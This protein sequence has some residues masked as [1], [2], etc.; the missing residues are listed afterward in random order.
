MGIKDLQL[1]VKLLLICIFTM[2]IMAISLFLQTH[3]EL[4]HLKQQQLEQIKANSLNQKKHELQSIVITA[5]SSLSPIQAQDNNKQQAMISKINQ[6]K[7]SDEGYFFINSLDGYGIANGKNQKVTNKYLLKNADGSINTNINN[8]IEQAKAGG[9]FLQ[10]SGRKPGFGEAKFPKLTYVKPIPN[11]QWFI[12]ASF[13]IDDIDAI[14]AQQHNLVDNTVTEIIVSN[15]WLTGLLTILL[16]CL[17]TWAVHQALSPLDKMHTKL[18]DIARGNGDLTKQL[19]VINRD[20]IGKCSTAFNDFSNKIKQLVIDVNIQAAQIKSA[21]QDLDENALTNQN[22]IANQK[23]KSE[24]LATAI[25]ELLASAEEIAAS[26]Q[27]AAKETVNA[28][29]SGN[30]TLQSIDLAI[31]KLVEL[32][33]KITATA[34]AAQ[35]FKHETDAIEKVLEVI[36][37]VAEQTNL[38][39]L[40]AAI[41]AARAGEYGKGFSVV[42]DEVRTLASKTRASTEEINLL[43]SKLQNSSNQAYL[44]MQASEQTSKQTM[45]EANKAKQAVQNMSHSI[46]SIND[47]NA[48]VAIGAKQQTTVTQQLNSNVHALFE[49]ADESSSAFI[50]ITSTSNALKS[51]ANKLAENMSQ[52]KV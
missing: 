7:F 29:L 18:Q 39:A 43:I 46:E 42:A 30:E 48:Q 35:D 21:S 3:S 23:Q 51:N 8:Q 13:F 10:Y 34:Q 52:F 12:G 40:N 41:E 5:L 25:N 31:A 19:P 32:S 1:K 17:A 49:L 28:S 44:A 50:E 14:I 36:Q 37:G 15:S 16:S 4:T 27:L 9:G 47:M 20:E 33:N 38:L 26:A 22:R 11:T 2:L 6:L 24:L 45:L